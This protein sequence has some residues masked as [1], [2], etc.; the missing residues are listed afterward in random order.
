LTMRSRER[1]VTRL[2][3]GAWPNRPIPAGWDYAARRPLG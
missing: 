1:S 2:M 3:L